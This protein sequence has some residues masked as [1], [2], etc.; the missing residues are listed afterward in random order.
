MVHSGRK[1]TE[2]TSWDGIDQMAA[3]F[4]SKNHH[5]IVQ[6]S[7]CIVRRIN[8]VGLCAQVIEQCNRGV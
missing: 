6:L 8:E 5:L 1:G 2:S 3:K 4:G 7:P